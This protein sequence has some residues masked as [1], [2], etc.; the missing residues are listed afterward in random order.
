VPNVLAASDVCLHVLRPDPLFTGALPSKVLEYLGAHRP[1]ITTV[2]GVPAQLAAESDGGF[3]PTPEDL[4]REFRRWRAMSPDERRSHGERAFRYGV[5]RF[6]LA[7][8]VGKLEEL[9]VG[10]I[11]ST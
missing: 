10:T 3:A 6:S 4:V 9:L 8:N 5:E 7:V 2:P 11:R 1:F